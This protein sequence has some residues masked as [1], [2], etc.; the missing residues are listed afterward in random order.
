M[1][2]EVSDNFSVCML[3]LFFEVTSSLVAISIVKVVYGHEQEPF[4]ISHDPAKFGGHWHCDSGELMV[5][6]CRMFLKEH[7]IK[8]PCDPMGRTHSR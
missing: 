8:G 6:V 1:K 7:L 3:K 4:T 2:Q 5:L